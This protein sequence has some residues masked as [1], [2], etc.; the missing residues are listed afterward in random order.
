MKEAKPLHRLA[1][2]AGMLVIVSMSLIVVDDIFGDADAVKY[3]NVLGYRSQ[4][5]FEPDTRGVLA[6]LEVEGLTFREFEGGEERFF[7]FDLPMEEAERLY[8]NYSKT[9]TDFWTTDREWVYGT[10]SMWDDSMKPM[11]CWV[12]GQDDDSSNLFCLSLIEGR[13][14]E[15]DKLMDKLIKAY[16]PR[17]KLKA[18]F[19]E[20]DIRQKDARW[21]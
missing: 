2:L 1:R 8:R 4:T 3:G 14:K 7:F 10:Y 18:S 9:E 13:Y 5:M 15:Y 19:W 12:G 20:A 21:T 16:P 17:Q 6:G 11:T